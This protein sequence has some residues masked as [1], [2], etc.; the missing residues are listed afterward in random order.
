MRSGYSQATKLFLGGPQ[1][2]SLGDT[3]KKEWARDL[4]GLSVMIAN[5]AS[6]IAREPLKV[7]QTV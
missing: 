6:P 3:S 2:A 4:S 7:K 1:Q 5:P